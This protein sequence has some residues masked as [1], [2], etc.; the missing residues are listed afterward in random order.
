MPKNSFFLLMKKGLLCFFFF[1]F[2]VGSFFIA[3]LITS[4]DLSIKIVSISNSTVQ[5]SYSIYFLS[6]D[7]DSFLS[8][9]ET[10][11]ALLL[12]NGS[13]I[14]YQKEENNYLILNTFLTKN[15]ADLVKNKYSEY[16]FSIVEL[17]FP[18]L[19]YNGQNKDLV[20]TFF[21]E[22]KQIAKE[23][24]EIGK[25][26][27]NSYYDNFLFAS[28]INSWQEIFFALV[29]NFN[30]KKDLSSFDKYVQI[31]AN[32]C[33]D[34]ISQLSSQTSNISLISR[35]ITQLFLQQEK[36]YNLCTKI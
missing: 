26:M 35:T 19:S 9:S 29:T 20:K 33:Y 31:C 6:I 3:S 11:K 21:S 36:F 10:D 30:S 22:L 28:K 5:Q 23:M 15:D 25:T 16:P 14:F 13:G 1:I 27:Q 34:T 2:L 8:Q 24:F 18:T 4:S 12:K 32:N 7:Y 17:T